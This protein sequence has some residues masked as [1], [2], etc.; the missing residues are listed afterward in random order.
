MGKISAFVGHSFL[1]EDEGAVR[2]FT[3]FFDGIA[4]GLDFDWIHATEPRPEDVAA[5][6]LELIEGRNLFI[7]I[8]TPNERVAKE[9]RFTNP[10]WG[11]HLK[12][13]NED[14]ESKTSDWIIQGNV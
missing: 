11:K 9:N 4:K 6:V 8:C 3:D 13:K 1:Q 14:L 12:I 7:G 2:K 10:Y 5:K